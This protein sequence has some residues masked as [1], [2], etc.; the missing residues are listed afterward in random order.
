[1]KYFAL[2]VATLAGTASAAVSK[3]DVSVRFRKYDESPG[4]TSK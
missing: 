2:V 1:M 4:V 3:P